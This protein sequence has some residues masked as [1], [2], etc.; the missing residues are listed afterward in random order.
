MK[1]Y[2][3]IRLTVLLSLVNLAYAQEATVYRLSVK[4][5]V[6]YALSH[7]KDLKNARVDVQLAEQDVRSYL[8]A[9]YPQINSSAN[10]VYNAILPTSLF[11]TSAF[12]GK[13]GEYQAAKFGTKYNLTAG[14]SGR[15]L[16]F[17]GTFFVGLKA[18]REYV[19]L[20]RKNIRRSEI[21]TAAAI[22]KAYYSVLVNRERLGT[23]ETSITQLEALLKET[24]AYLD[25]GFA[26]KLDVDRL[27]VNLNNLRTELEKT[28]QLVELSV[29][30]LKF[31]MGMDVRAQLE[32]TDVINPQDF[33]PQIPVEGPNV[34]NRVE[35]DVLSQTIHLQDLNLKRL[36]YT[37]L[38][39][40]S[41]YGNMQTQAQRFKFDFYEYKQQ[42]YPISSVGLQ[43]DFPI[44][45]GF[46]RAAALQKARLDRQK[47]QYEIDDLDNAVQ[48]EYQNAKTQ[49]TNNLRTLDMERRNLDLAQEVYRVTKIKYEEGV[50]TNLEVI[51]ADGDLKQARTN[52]FNNLLEAYISLVDL[53]KAMGTLQ[54]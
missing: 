17:D 1:H 14:V 34:Q 54:P 19:E 53:Q 16:L 20:S 7:Q 25:N 43:I 3:I 9:G 31:Q 39:T 35:Y 42:W 13:P 40:A 33:N 41:L 24:Q 23:L 50:G 44:F 52:Y 32:T 46:R 12:G 38:P 18:A 29:N 48:F 47:L 6:Q 4:E 26:E 49:L 2:L 45:D 27:Q 15:Q 28:R 30:L 37:W 51:T 36:K 11:P 5:C 8:A 21:E 10:A 22:T